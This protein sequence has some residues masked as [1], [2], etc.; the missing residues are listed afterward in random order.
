MRLRLSV[1]VPARERVCGL[2]LKEAPSR[3]GRESLPMLAFASI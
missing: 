2:F 3:F 1:V